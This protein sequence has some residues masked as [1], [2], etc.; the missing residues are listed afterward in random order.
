MACGRDIFRDH[1]TEQRKR[2]F[3]MM[4]LKLAIKISVCIISIAI[5]LMSI[6]S[7]LN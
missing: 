4:P 7:V 1:T 5:I 2:H 3:F 6:G